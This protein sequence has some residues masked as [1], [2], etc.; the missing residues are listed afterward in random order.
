MLIGS[1]GHEPCRNAGGGV[2]FQRRGEKQMFAL[3]ISPRPVPG[4]RITAP[5]RHAKRANAAGRREVNQAVAYTGPRNIEKQ[6][7]V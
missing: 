5:P 3:L 1:A 7:V 6:A 4:Q 2:P